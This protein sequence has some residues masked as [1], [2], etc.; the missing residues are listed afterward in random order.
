ME[1][2]HEPLSFLYPS[3]FFAFSSQ[4]H[5][6]DRYARLTLRAHTKLQTTGT[7]PY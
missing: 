5:R 7:K 3:T 6:E 4:A 1:A 2:K